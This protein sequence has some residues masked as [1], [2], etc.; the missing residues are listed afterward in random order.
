MPHARI[1]DKRLR[2]PE[3]LNTRIKKG[4]EKVFINDMRK[5]KKWTT[6]FYCVPKESLLLLFSPFRTDGDSRYTF[7]SN[8]K[9]RSVSNF[10]PLSEHELSKVG[11]FRISDSVLLLLIRYQSSIF[12]YFPSRKHTRSLRSLNRLGSIDRTRSCEHSEPDSTI[13]SILVHDDKNRWIQPAR[14]SPSNF[15]YVRSFQINR[16]TTTKRV[17]VKRK[18]KRRRVE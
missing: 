17:F 14:S 5:I 12:V 15:F 1:D 9:S 3:F 7:S 13:P 16:E 11:F 18:K 2:D 8:F 4:G 10:R 6:Y